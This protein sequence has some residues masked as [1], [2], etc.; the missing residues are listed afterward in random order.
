MTETADLAWQ[1][2][3]A[4]VDATPDALAGKRYHQWVD[5]GRPPL[6]V[7]DGATCGY[8]VETGE[9]VA[10][11]E[12]DAPTYEDCGKP[13]RFVVERSDGDESFGLLGGG[14]ES[15]E[16]HLAETVAGM[17]GGDE[18]RAV[19]SIRWDKP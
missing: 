5:A 9:T 2:Y 3:L 15:C 19:V 4:A 10:L 17:I 11:V 12:G 14:E 8:G 13:S 6:H 1:K 7:E 16:E 18:V